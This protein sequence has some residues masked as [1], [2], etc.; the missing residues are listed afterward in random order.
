MAMTDSET[1]R[2]EGSSSQR[3]R[4]ENEKENKVTLHTALILLM[5]SNPQSVDLEWCGQTLYIPIGKD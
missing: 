5:L 4:V 3:G 1:E 2:G